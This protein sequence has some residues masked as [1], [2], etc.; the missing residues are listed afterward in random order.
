MQQISL[1]LS[2]RSPA[3]SVLAYQYLNDYNRLQLA[4]KTDCAMEMKKVYR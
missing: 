3:L 4:N 2:L 1:Q